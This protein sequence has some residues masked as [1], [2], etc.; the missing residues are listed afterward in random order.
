MERAGLSEGLD[1]EAFDRLAGLAKQITSAGAAFISIVESDRDFYLGQ[2]GLPE[3]LATTR[4]LPHQTF[5]SLTLGRST[6]VVID[7]T[8][9]DPVFASVPTVAM[10]LRSVENGSWLPTANA[11]RAA[12]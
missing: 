4:T 1:T 3:P 5:C 11:D 2:S 10:Y 6:P 12:R 9:A 8:S 7:D